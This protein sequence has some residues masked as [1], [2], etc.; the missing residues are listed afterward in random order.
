MIRA[1]RIMG[2]VLL[3]AGTTIG[4]GMLAVPVMTSF[5]GFGLSL[6]LF[7]VCWL[8]MLASAFF[9]IDVNCAYQDE[10]NMITMASR[11]LG[12][13]GKT[14]SW[15][16]YMLLLYVLVAAYIAASGPIFL[17]GIFALTGWNMPPAF[18]YFCLPLLFGSFVYFGTKGV[19]VV[20]RL[21]M[22]GLILSYLV[23]I[24]F[25]PQHVDLERLANFNPYAMGVGIPVLITSFGYHII[26]P[27]LSTYMGHDRR[28]LRLS[29]I[30][31]SLMSLVIYALWQFL[32]IGA[33]PMVGEVSLVSQWKVGGGAIAP[34]SQILHE[35]WVGLGAKFFSFF[36]VITSFLGVS[37]SLSDFLVD[38]LKIKKTWEG[39]LG[40]WL[41]TFIPPLV[42]VFT[43]EKG[44]Y[45]ALEY[46]GAFVAVLLIFLPAA[47]AWT[48][49]SSKFYQSIKGRLYLA[50]VILFSFAIILVDVMNQWGYFQPVIDNYLR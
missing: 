19:D 48:L 31:G 10:T 8:F 3:V 18:S 16:F 42:F 9:F 1:N 35:H 13:F 24:V 30:L 46:A 29:V 2:G 27:S 21:L 22:L 28:A 47:M 33:V 44:F 26:I 14:V 34:L 5:M 45:L 40:A 11:T 17:E 37:L 39:K 25:V 20:N 7:L 41:L 49:K 36:A 23:L 32:V 4:G 6:A 50:S 15:L 12:I 38:G 43:Y